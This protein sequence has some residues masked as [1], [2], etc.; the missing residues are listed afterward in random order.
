M[1]TA[2]S[3]KAAGPRTKSRLL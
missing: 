1:N 2:L 3:P